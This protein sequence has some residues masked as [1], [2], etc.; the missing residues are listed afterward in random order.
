MREQRRLR[1]RDSNPDY[2]LAP[3][4]FAAETRGA[5]RLYTRP[6]T[7]ATKLSLVFASCRHV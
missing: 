1:G 2:S 4:G 3:V 6:A 5:R 7:I